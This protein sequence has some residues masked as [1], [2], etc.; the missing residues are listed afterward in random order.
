MNNEDFN[1]PF[2][3]ILHIIKEGYKDDKELLLLFS[4]YIASNPDFKY[5]TTYL[6]DSI[7]QFFIDYRMYSRKKLI[8]EDIINCLNSLNSSKL[9]IE[10]EFDSK[11]RYNT[12][13]NSNLEIVLNNNT[14]VDSFDFHKIGSRQFPFKIIQ[15]KPKRIEYTHL[16]DTDDKSKKWKKW[17]S[18][19]MN[20]VEKQK[21][22]K[23]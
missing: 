12:V 10:I 23:K 21:N 7:D 17:V 1:K 11:F 15:V 16:I 13:S 18:D 5:N 2:R 9:E 22:E 8:F 6:T 20:I 4:S 19:F 14:Y 3:K